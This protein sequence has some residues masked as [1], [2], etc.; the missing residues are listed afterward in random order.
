MR[1]QA[2]RRFHPIDRPADVKRQRLISAV[3]QLGVG[4]AQV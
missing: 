1:V 4:G 3:V 2:P